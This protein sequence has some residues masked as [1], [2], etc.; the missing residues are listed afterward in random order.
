MHKLAEALYKAGAAET[1]AAGAAGA[2][3]AGAAGDPGDGDVIDAEFTEEG[4]SSS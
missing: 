3:A 4:G 2:G 1:G